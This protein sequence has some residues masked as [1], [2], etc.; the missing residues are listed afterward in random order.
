MKVG[1]LSENIWKRSIRKMLPNHTMNDKGAG[2]GRDCALF[3][4]VKEVSSENNNVCV[5]NSAV[6]PFCEKTGMLSV[7]LASNMI[8]G[9][10]GETQGVMLNLF[11]DGNTSEESMAHI[12][13][14]V[15]ETSKK[16]E[17]PISSF[18]VHILH[19][20]KKPYMLASAIGIRNYKYKKS[21]MC[22]DIVVIG[23]VGLAGTLMILSAYENSQ[24]EELYR[25]FPEKYLNNALKECQKLSLLKYV[26]ILKKYDI[27]YSRALGE[28]GIF[29]ALWEMSETINTGINVDLKKIPVSQEVVEI[30]NFYNINPYVLHSGGSMIICAYDAEKIVEDFR[31]QGIYAEM[32]GKITDDNDKVIVNDEE[33]RFITLPQIDE[34]YKIF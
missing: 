8:L 28:G 23:N 30:C 17:V 7:L 15:G 4:N 2:I 21:E 27:A 32:I 25:Y 9:N 5:S 13:K 3:S 11:L 33:K 22:R 16:I 10:M 19:G 18:D 20:L 31:E 29:G 1:K 34:I 24:K 26:E 6:I 12:S 14:Q